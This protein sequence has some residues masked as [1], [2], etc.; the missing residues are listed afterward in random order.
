MLSGVLGRAYRPAVAA[1]G[2]SHVCEVPEKPELCF[3]HVA[4]PSMLARMS[5]FAALS[6]LPRPQ[7]STVRRRRRRRNP[8]TLKL[9]CHVLRRRS[10]PDS[11][12]SPTAQACEACCAGN[13]AS[14]SVDPECSRARIVAAVTGRRMR[15]LSQPP[16]KQ[17]EN[18]A[19]PARAKTLSFARRHREGRPPRMHTAGAAKGLRPPGWP[20]VLPDGL[21]APR[22]AR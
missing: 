21:S 14:I 20:C 10:S 3:V 4:P 1:I 15:R 13:V 17:A 9:L 12:I 6:S 8:A 19:R 7:V 11:P 2:E 18:A 16:G 22:G 5:P